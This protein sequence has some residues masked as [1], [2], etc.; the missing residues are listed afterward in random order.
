MLCNHPHDVRRLFSIKHHGSRRLEI[1]SWPAFGYVLD[2]CRDCRI[3]CDVVYFVKLTEHPN[4]VLRIDGN[5]SC[6]LWLFCCA[7][8]FVFLVTLVEDKNLV[9]AESSVFVDK[10]LHV[11]LYSVDYIPSLTDVDTCRIT[12]FDAAKEVTVWVLPTKFIFHSLTHECYCVMDY[13]CRKWKLF[14]L[15]CFHNA[16]ICFHIQHSKSRS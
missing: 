5:L 7:F 4:Q 12:Y 2:F 11:V 15:V 10:I 13:G 6:V 3:Y 16:K 8:S 9:D 14:D 1:I